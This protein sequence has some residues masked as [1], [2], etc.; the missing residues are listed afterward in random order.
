MKSM[1]YI[2]FGGAN[3]VSDLNRNQNRGTTVTG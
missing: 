1:L 3:G 2:G